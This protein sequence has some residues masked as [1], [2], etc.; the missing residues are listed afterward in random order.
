HDE[1]TD[2]AVDGDQQATDPRHDPPADEASVEQHEHASEHDRHPFVVHG[3]TS[4][5]DISITSLCGRTVPDCNA[6]AVASPRETATRL[7][8]SEFCDLPATGLWDFPDAA[9]RGSA[10]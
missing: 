9:R 2:V 5:H 10:R 1:Q 7:P 4:P 3:S 6:L 8:G